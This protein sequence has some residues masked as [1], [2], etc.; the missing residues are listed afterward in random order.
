MLLT[1]LKTSSRGNRS[2]EY[3]GR[4]MIFDCACSIKACMELIW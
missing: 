1:L 4:N 3:G 2:G